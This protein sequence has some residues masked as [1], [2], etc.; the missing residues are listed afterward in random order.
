ML[1]DEPEAPSL[2]RVDVV[3]PVLFS[4]MVSLAALWRWA[5][6]TPMQSSATPRARSP[7]HMWPEP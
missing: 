7:R 1:H 5:G 2:E 6:I 4:V 3:Q